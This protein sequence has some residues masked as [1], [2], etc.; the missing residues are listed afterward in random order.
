ML[1]LNRLPRLYHPL[2]KT[3]R[4]ALVTHDKFFVVVEATDP[5]FSDTE[6]CQL[7]ERAGARH[8]EEV[9]D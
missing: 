9:R 1:I 3:A 7:L 8:I 4:F 2:F 5:R 6:T